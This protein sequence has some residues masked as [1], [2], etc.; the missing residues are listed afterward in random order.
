LQ[1][2]LP[3]RPGGG[4]GGGI[5]GH[6]CGCGCLWRYVYGQQRHHR[7][8]GPP[9]QRCLDRSVGEAGQLVLAR[10]ALRFSD[11]RPALY[12][13]VSEQQLIQPVLPAAAYSPF[14]EVP[15]V[16][17]VRSGCT[18]CCLLVVGLAVLLLHCVLSCQS[19]WLML[20]CDWLRILRGCDVHN[21]LSVPV[22]LLQPNRF[23]PYRA[24]DLCPQGYGVNGRVVC[25]CGV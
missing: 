6:G 7:G 8:A 3:S 25:R 14:M 15:L 20:A 4:T 21:L 12:S 10:P 11:C 9:A 5:G 23:R 13:A 2:S 16:R 18:V 1:L 22:F 17:L 24:R 19:S